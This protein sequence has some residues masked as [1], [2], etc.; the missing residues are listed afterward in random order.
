V[1][2]HQHRWKEWIEDPRVYD[3]LES[4]AGELKRSWKLD[5]K[6]PQRFPVNTWWLFVQIEDK[7]KN[8]PVLIAKSRMP[9]PPGPPEKLSDL[10]AER[11]IKA[12]YEDHNDGSYEDA[13]KLAATGYKEGHS[14]WRKIKR[15]LDVAYVILN[16]GIDFAP[17]PRVQFL[18]RRMLEIVESKHLRDQTLGGVVEFFDDTCPCGHKH[19]ADA[20]RKLKKR[21]GRIGL[22]RDKKP[23][24]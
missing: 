18:H 24:C 21:A 15:A 22:R 16:H 13:L 11:T 20:I 8:K 23:S 3:L 19:Q 2:T 10:I 12:A 5:K 9:P 14:A 6:Y 7:L 4:L 17:M 1:S